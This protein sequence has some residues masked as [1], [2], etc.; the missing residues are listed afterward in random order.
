MAKKKVMRKLKEE[1]EKKGF[2]LSVT[3]NGKEGQ[4]KMIASCGFL[5]N[6]ISQFMKRRR[7]DDGRQC[8][9]VG[10]PLEN[11]SQELGSERKSEKKEV[12]S[13]I[14]ACKAFQKNYM[15]LGVNKL[16]RA[17]MVPARTWRVHA[18]VIAPTERLIIDEADGSSSG[19]Q[20]RA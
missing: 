16:L 11:Q 2:K 19:R 1:V 8:G 6:E 4:S 20:K 17:G 7:S 13:E 3:E 18:V 15:K 12:H 14:L 5:E 10:S 9:N